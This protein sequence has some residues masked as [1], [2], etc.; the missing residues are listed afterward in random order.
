L[1]LH[2]HGFDA[3]RS[4]G[5]FPEAWRYARDQAARDHVVTTLRH[6]AVSLDAAELFVLALADGT[7]SRESIHEEMATVVQRRAAIPASGEMPD[8]NAILVRLG[9]LGLMVR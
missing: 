4:P 7:R 2:R 8:V 5:E 6:D 1:E 9:E 3:I